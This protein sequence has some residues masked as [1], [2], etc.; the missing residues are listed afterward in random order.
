MRRGTGLLVACLL[1]G[2]LLASCAPAASPAPAPKPAP[3]PGAAPTPAP[4][5]APA[6]APK[7]KPKIVDLAV[8]TGPISSS[9]YR[10]TLVLSEMLRLHSDFVRITPIASKG[11]VENLTMHLAGQTQLFHASTQNITEFLAG[12]G[13][14]T[15]AGPQPADRIQFLMSHGDT[16]FTFVVRADSDIY[17]LKDLKGKKVGVTEPGSSAYDF[18]LRLTA[19]AGIDLLKDTRPMFGSYA[20]LTSAMKEG[21]IQAWINPHVY[22]PGSPYP[23]VEDV[24]NATRVRFVSVA[25]A[26]LDKVNQGLGGDVF[27]LIRLPAGTY[28]GQTSDAYWPG[29][30]QFWTV[31]KT[32]GEDAAYDIARVWFSYYDQAVDMS[33]LAQDVSRERQTAML[34]AKL[35]LSWHAGALKYFKEVGWTK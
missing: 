9:A 16:Q 3:A 21:A 35:P 22:T 1:A 27:S 10:K 2:L 20:D 12:K 15:K 33:P 11:V 34:K 7:A 4:A 17:A 30:P 31:A 5:P 14:F 26:E 13:S 8:P 18:A 19:A 6:A 23:Y 24:A 29:Q 25:Q 32:L 28:R